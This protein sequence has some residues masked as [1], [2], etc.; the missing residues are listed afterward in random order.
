LCVKELVGIFPL[1][2]RNAVWLGGNLWLLV[3]EL[4]AL[5]LLGIAL[6]A[7]WGETNASMQRIK[8]TQDFIARKN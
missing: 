1:F 7:S 3:R 8:K 4:I 6:R 2:F 5:V